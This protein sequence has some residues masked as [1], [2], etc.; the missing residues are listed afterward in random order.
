MG[1]DHKPYTQR[2]HPE[3]PNHSPNPKKSLGWQLCL[4]FT[5]FI[6][7]LTWA[8]VVE[9]AEG[10]PKLKPFWRDRLERER[11][12]IE[13]AEQYALIA[14]ISGMYQPAN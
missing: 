3:N 6:M 2:H 4:F 11:R 8:D 12:E 5:L 9:W 7:A 1:A 14:R 10:I 13:E